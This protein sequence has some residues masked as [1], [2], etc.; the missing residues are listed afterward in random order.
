MEPLP[1]FSSP[2]KFDPVVENGVQ[3]L[4]S[5]TADDSMEIAQS[6]FGRHGDTATHHADELGLQVP[7]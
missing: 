6:E 4:A 1:S 2:Q 5:Y 3:Q 7:S